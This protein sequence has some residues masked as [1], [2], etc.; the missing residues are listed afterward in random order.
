MQF[1]IHRHASDAAAVARMY[2]FSCSFCERL[3]AS[4]YV[5]PWSSTAESAKAGVR[6]HVKIYPISGGGTAVPWSLL[7]YETKQRGPP[8]TQV[9]AESGTGL[10]RTKSLRVGPAKISLLS[11]AGAITGERCA[12]GRTTS[13]ETTPL[14]LESIGAAIYLARF[15]LARS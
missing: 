3:K 14:K 12:V 7:L 8:V 13:T 10:E 15:L 4:H 1:S 6:P 5:P 2:R 11:R 9:T